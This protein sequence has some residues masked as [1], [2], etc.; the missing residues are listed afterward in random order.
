[1]SVPQNGVITRQ[2]LLELG[3]DGAKPITLISAPA[4]YGKTTLLRQW[5][6]VS[7]AVVRLD[8]A[9]IGDGWELWHQVDAALRLADVT[10]ILDDVHL[11]DGGRKTSELKR[12]FD[13]AGSDRRLV[14]ATR[15]DPILELHDARLAGNVLE[16]RADDLAF[17]EA[18]TRLFLAMNHITATPE[19]ARA[20]WMYTEGWPA[21]LRLS[22]TPLS[23]AAGSQEAFA[24]L[25]H[26]DTAV[27]SYLMGQAL[28][29]TSEELRS[30]LLRTSVSEFLD[31]TLAQELTGRS[32]AG[33][34]LE[35][36]RSQPG[37]LHRLSGGPW[38]YRYHP[39]FRALLLA[40]LMRSAPEDARRLSALAAAWFLGHGDHIRAATL[41]AQGGAWDVLAGA[42]LEGSCVALA[43][44]D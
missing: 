31:A 32:D 12:A 2:R 44:G 43:T 10:V 27:G 18:E 33:L 21:G 15:R 25:L 41:S 1:M 42:L 19:Q 40:E 30:F 26:G 28:S 14:I 36:A 7:G 3:G 16:I 17:D 38:P 39:M 35:L 29:C 23:R 37:F 9:E 20:L 34:L 4:G 24:T 6:P 13:L 5:A 22:T 8:P 11:L